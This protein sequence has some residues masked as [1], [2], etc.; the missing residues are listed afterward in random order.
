[1]R[2]RLL[3]PLQPEVS[4]PPVV[5]PSLPTPQPVVT[6]TAPPSTKNTK[7]HF[8]LKNAQPLEAFKTQ[9]S[10]KAPSSDTLK[11]TVYPG[12][13]ESFDFSKHIRI[14]AGSDFTV[15]VLPD[16]RYVVGYIELNVQK[17]YHQFEVGGHPY[18]SQPS[19]ITYSTTVYCA[20]EL[21]FDI[22]L[23]K[24][25]SA[26]AAEFINNVTYAD[27]LEFLCN[28]WVPPFLDEILY[29]I[30]PTFDAKGTKCLFIPT[31]AAYLIEHDY[32]RTLP[33]PKKLGRVR[34]PAF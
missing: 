28:C 27:L 7:V 18:V 21:L 29:P 33:L 20:T 14:N 10:V 3:Q 8:E 22:S 4:N 24:T 23:R 5:P 11:K 2:P 12:I 34:Y 19:L 1:M 25:T 9:S 32:G 6:P 15:D 26:A 16:Y 13:F 17:L 30:A 31:L